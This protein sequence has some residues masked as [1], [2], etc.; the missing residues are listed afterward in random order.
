M[1]ELLKV[2]ATEDSIQPIGRVSQRVGRDSFKVWPTLLQQSLKTTGKHT[3]LYF[4]S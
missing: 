1:G 3:Y 4:N 2:A